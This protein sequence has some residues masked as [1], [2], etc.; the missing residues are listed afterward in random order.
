MADFTARFNELLSRAAGN[1]TAIAEALG[2]SKQTIS[3]W[4]NGTRFPKKPAV[5]TIA[6]YF[7]VGVPWLEG[8]TD[9]ETPISYPTGNRMPPNVRPVSELHHQR[10]P[11]IGSVAAGEP[12]Y[13]PDDL[14]VYVN[15]P[16]DCD[17]ALTVQGDSMTP[18]YLDGDIVYVK[19]R[20]DVPEG[21]VAVVFL[22]DEATLKHVYKRETGLTLWSDNPAYPPMMIEFE[23]YSN[24]RIFGVPV[25]FT[26]I[27]K[28]DPRKMLK[29]GL[30]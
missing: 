7:G 29:K 23:D 4:K 26:R 2:V 1:D 9:D 24:V 10:I 6:D 17:A 30:K 11:H 25:G 27:Y 12:I 18:T 19:C 13:A 5:R 20:P 22:D 16:V 8:V 14:G 28:K 15:S 3:A 21:A